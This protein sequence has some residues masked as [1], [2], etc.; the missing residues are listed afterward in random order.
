MPLYPSV[1]EN[2]IEPFYCY[3]PFCHDV[4]EPLAV[5]QYNAKMRCIRRFKTEKHKTI[6][7]WLLYL[8]KEIP[9]F[10]D[11]L[12]NHRVF[13]IV[14]IRIFRQFNAPLSVYGTAEVVA[15]KAFINRSSS[16]FKLNAKIFLIIKQNAPRFLITQPFRQIVCCFHNFCMSQACHHRMWHYRYRNIPPP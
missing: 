8:L 14:R 2:I 3:R 16:V 9:A 5:V 12:M 7:L 13:R 15:I 6:R 4:N 11:K 1:P 10:V